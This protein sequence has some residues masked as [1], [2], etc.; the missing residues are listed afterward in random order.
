MFIWVKVSALR[1]MNRHINDCNLRYNRLKNMILR[2]Y[3]GRLDDVRIQKRVFQTKAA[4]TLHWGSD[5]W[6][7]AKGAKLEVVQISY[8]KRY[9]DLNDL[10]S[11][12]VLKGDLEFFYL[13]EC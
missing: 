3:F 13:K 1:E 7:F 4:S 9:L 8:F 5:V 12:V 2:S 6:G 10:F 11:S